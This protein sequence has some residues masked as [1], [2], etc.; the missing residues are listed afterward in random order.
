[1]STQPALFISH[2]T[3]MLALAESTGPDADEYARALHAFGRRLPRPRGIVVVSAHGTSHPDELVEVSIGHSTMLEY[4][5]RGFPGEL[6]Q[7]EYPAPGDPDLSARVA[8]LLSAGGFQASLS[9]TTR[10]DHGVWVPL[11]LAFP[12]ADIPVVQVSMPYPGDPRL[13]LKLGKALA[14]LRR[15]GIL[16]V[17]SGGGVHNLSELQWHAKSGAAEPWALEFEEWALALIRQ[18]NVE[19]LLEF[20]DESPVAARA[21]PTPEHFYPIFFTIGAALPGDE[22]AVLHRGVEYGTLS[23]L[24]FALEQSAP[25]P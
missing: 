21:H 8:A 17:G 7:V 2:G 11:R 20:A 3:P 4:D 5:F 13:V 10:L 18:K 22:P 24:T 23:M 15:D 16:L 25:R 19:T 14:E 9:T 12:E 6:Y 1:M